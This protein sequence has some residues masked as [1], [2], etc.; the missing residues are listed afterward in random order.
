MAFVQLA[1]AAAGTLFSSNSTLVPGATLWVYETETETPISVFADR[2]GSVP[3][4]QP[5]QTDEFG[6]APGWA[7]DGQ[8]VDFVYSFNGASSDP[9]SAELLSASVETSVGAEAALRAAADTAEASARAGAISTEATTR[10]T[11]DTTLGAAIT[12]ENASRVAADTTLT[13]NLAAEATTRATNDGLAAQKA[14][15]LS[16]VAD[17]GTSRAN[18]HIPALTPAA[19]VAVANVPT[20][21]GLLTFD[22]Y[23]LSAG[24]IVLLT[25]QTSAIANG[26]YTAAAGA[27][28]RPTELAT[29]VVVKARTVDI[30]QGTKYG[31]SRWLLKTNTT[32]TVD[33][34]S[35]NW[36]VESYVPLS[37]VSGSAAGLL[38]MR[39]KGRRE[40]VDEITAPL[41]TSPPLQSYSAATGLV[42]SLGSVSSI[43]GGALIP[44]TDARFRYLGGIPVPWTGSGYT[45]NLVAFTGSNPLVASPSLYR[46]GR[47]G[48][49]EFDVDCQAFEIFEY[50]NALQW[51]NL[52]IDG[53]PVSAEPVPQSSIAALTAGSLYLR[54]VDFG[55]RGHH[56]VRIYLEAMLFGGIWLAKADTLQP[57]TTGDSLLHLHIGDSYS[58]TGINGPSNDTYRAQDNFV[59][60]FARRLGIANIWNDGYGGTGVVATQSGTVPAYGT[61]SA[62]WPASADTITVE[63]SINDSF[64]ITGA[65]LTGAALQ[66]ATVTL[67]AQLRTLYPLAPIVLFGISRPGNPTAGDTTAN[68]AYGAALASMSDANMFFVDPLAAAWFTGSG[69]IGAPAGDGNADFCLSSDGNHPTTEGHVAL[70]DHWAAAVS[71]AIG[72][73]MLD[74][75]APA[76]GRQYVQRATQQGETS[77]VLTA[78]PV[79]AC[80]VL[81]NKVYRVSALLYYE[82]SV[83]AGFQFS[84]AAPAGAT[85]I[86]GIDGVMDQAITDVVAVAGSGAGVINSIA[87]VGLLVMGA[88][89]GTLALKAAQSVVAITNLDANP[90]YETNLS[91]TTLNTLGMV[92]TPTLTQSSTWADQGTFSAKVDGTVSVLPN[93]LQVEIL[94]VASPFAV[95]AG[96]TYQFSAKVNVTSP[97]T[98]GQGLQMQI[99]WRTSGGVTISTAVLVLGLVTGVNA[100]SLN[101]VAPPTAA[102]AELFI[103]EQSGTVGDH[104]TFYVDTVSFGSLDTNLDPGSCL[105]VEPLGQ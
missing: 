6:Q 28:A 99:Q 51:S 42:A 81:A 76:T 37:V 4:P 44:W 53:K 71:A 97:P 38:A 63:G 25:A 75:A 21:S 68:T 11:N 94:N 104:I 16:D 14:A 17:P 24:D 10:S 48:W 49:V 15:N 8:T 70:G 102:Q 105:C 85:M 33:S 66:A 84:F 12:T 29:N 56:T 26:L 30:I 77:A 79:L 35:Q 91:G 34:S 64:M 40:I 98:T 13:T 80:Q 95:T 22:G 78:D 2:A 54:R 41:M 92:A 5:L 86:W 3:L 31:G 89:S 58:S 50:G 20:L 82:S 87:V 1:G 73:P 7:A 69:N 43:A 52:W 45:T 32:V 74:G 59:F 67:L 23:T 9:L 46:D 18:L 61:R 72:I 96:K 60:R 27:W 47:V 62:G 65:T 101:S 57:P 39:R 90:G 100:L 19:C 83:A 88:T 103:V 93:F 55:S 36:I